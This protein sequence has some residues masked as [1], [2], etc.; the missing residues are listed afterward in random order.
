M[1]RVV[2]GEGMDAFMDALTQEP[3]LNNPTLTSSSFLLHFSQSPK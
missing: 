2:Q 1:Q 3:S